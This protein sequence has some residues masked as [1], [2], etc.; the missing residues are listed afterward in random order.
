MC[1]HVKYMQE[2]TILTPYLRTEFH[3]FSVYSLQEPR[4]EF[5]AF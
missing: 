3:N 1:Q 2:M 4:I 5:G